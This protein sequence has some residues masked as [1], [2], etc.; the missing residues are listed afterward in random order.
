MT[1]K[2]RRTDLTGA[3]GAPVPDDWCLVDEKL[4][5]IARIYKVVGGP[6]DGN[7]FWAVQVDAQGRPWNSGTGYCATGKEAKETVE[8]MIA[9]FEGGDARPA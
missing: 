1:R 5:A 9:G 2:W 8:A 3:D 7:W 6:L 4:G